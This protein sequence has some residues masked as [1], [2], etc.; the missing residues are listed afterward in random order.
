MS[1]SCGNLLLCQS[2]LNP[3]MSFLVNFRWATRTLSHGSRVQ[4]VIYLHELHQF[5]KNHLRLPHEVRQCVSRFSVD[6]NECKSQVSDIRPSEHGVSFSEQHDSDLCNFP[7]RSMNLVELR[8]LDLDLG[9]FF[10]SA[11]EC[12]WDSRTRSLSALYTLVDDG[13]PSCKI[14][15][16]V[17]G[18]TTSLFLLRIS[19][20]VDLDLFTWISDGGIL[21][22]SSVSTIQRSPEQLPPAFKAYPMNIPRRTFVPNLCTR[23][24]SCDDTG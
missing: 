16:V 4:T 1:M 14:S 11:E 17:H 9:L 23:P 21:C 22:G 15:P 2:A 7:W 24:W 13:W 18:N 3:H 8:H 20:S 6:I 10:V 19:T 12:C 5:S